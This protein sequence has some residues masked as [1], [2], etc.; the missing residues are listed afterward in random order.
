MKRIVFLLFFLPSLL[1]AAPL[2][3]PSW[4]FW[5]D[6]PEGYAYVEGNNVDRYSF[7]GP[8][9]AMFDIAV[10][11]NGYE[12]TGAL[13]RDINRRLGNGGETAFFVYGDKNAA[14]ME[15]RF[16][17]F[18]GWGLCLELAGDGFRSPPLLLALAYSP[19]GMGEMDLFH[20]SALDSLAPSNAEKRIPGPIM[21]F[22]YP[23]GEQVTMPLAGTA[24]TAQ[25]RE[26]DA[27]AAQVLIEREFALLRHYEFAPNW[28]EAWIRYY[29]AIYRDSFDRVADAVVC[30]ARQWQGTALDDRAFAEKALALVQGYLYERDL[31]G[32]DFV[33]LVSAVTDGRGDCDSRAM[34]WAMILMQSNIPAG[35]MVSR[36]YGHAMG[37][38][39]IPGAGARFE[40]EGVKWL[41]AETTK[42]IS[43]GLIAQDMSNPEHWLGVFFD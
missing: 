39:D 28:Q 36:E 3:S 12:D 22:S 11:P 21:A 42:I 31:S 2:Y 13:V 20:L 34:L 23:R 33:N 40:T 6:L 26:H 14:L 7:Q 43:I 32:S 5:L 27:E 18:I 29:R 30:L 1:V 16:K 8:N 9:G 38:I 10:Y 41:V 19:A 24:A 37:I 17:G 35:M 4:G 25:F 15:L